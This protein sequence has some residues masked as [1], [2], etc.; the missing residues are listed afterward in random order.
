MSNAM[1]VAAPVSAAAAAAVLAVQHVTKDYFDGTR[2]LTVLRD[3]N[4]EVRPSETISIVGTS[5]AG[6]STL[7]HL[8]GALDRATSGTVQLCG[9]EY[10]TLNDQ[11]LADLRNRSIGFVF[12]FHHLLAEFTALENV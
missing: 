3:A 1:S 2:V 10:S 7:L 6:K 5:G 12:Q 11:Q 4:L 9:R 8:L